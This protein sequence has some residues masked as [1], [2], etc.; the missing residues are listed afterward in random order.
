MFGE[1]EIMKNLK[2]YTSILCVTPKVEIYYI[3]KEKFFF[4]LSSKKL[5]KQ[6]K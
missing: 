4:H 1:V 5:Y 2:R 6:L 3:T